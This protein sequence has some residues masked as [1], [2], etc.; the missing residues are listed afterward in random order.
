MASFRN[1]INLFSRS[2]RSPKTLICLLSLYLF[3]FEASDRVLK[4]VAM[5]GG[6]ITPWMFPNIVCD[7][8]L[9]MC[10]YLVFILLICDSSCFREQQSYELIRIGRPSW[11]MSQIMF[12]IIES[13]IFVLSI[14]LL[15]IIRSLRHIS[16]TFDWGLTIRQ[17]S[18]PNQFTGMI[19]SDL[20]QN[21]SAVQASVYCSVL[22]WLVCLFFSL[23]VM[24]LNR[25]VDR[26]ISIFFT[27]ALGLFDFFIYFYIDDANYLY[28]ISPTS[29]VNLTVIQNINGFSARRC[30]LILSIVNTILMILLLIMPV[31]NKKDAFIGHR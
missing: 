7:R 17:L 9:L 23:I 20:I 6:T 8:F 14:W 26:F 2:I 22:L 27:C 30:I 11:I 10:F 21:Y 25:L 1:T 12:A 15:L 16:F 4:Y 24:M 18:I 28:W 13:L 5:T 3:V 19:R 29:W 31:S